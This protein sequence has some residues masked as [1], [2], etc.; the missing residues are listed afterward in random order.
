MA[1][2]LFEPGKGPAGRP[3]ARPCDRLVAKLSACGDLSVEDREALHGVC[4]GAQEVPANRHIIRAGDKPEFIHV[5]VEGWAARAEILED[6]SRQ[7]TA[8]LIPGDFCDLHI[9]ILGEMDHDIIA[10]TDAKVAFVPHQIMEDLPRQRPELGRLC[11]GRPG[12]EAVLRAWISNI[13][14][15]DA[16]IA[17]PICSA[18]CTHG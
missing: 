5:M 13:G 9:T 16:I 2:Q 3:A 12:R 8:F 1:T 4:R 7:L 18:S 10:L 6:G 14:R 11:G 15:R 17:S